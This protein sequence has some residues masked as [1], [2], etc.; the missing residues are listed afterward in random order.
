MTALRFA[1][2]AL[3]GATSLAGC[4]PRTDTPSASTAAS[5]VSR[6]DGVDS[7]RVGDARVMAIL[8]GRAPFP[9]TLFQ[10]LEQSEVER[11]LRTGGEGSQDAQGKFA[12]GGSVWAF[13][14]DVG[15]KRVLVDTGGGSAMAAMGAGRLAGRL[16]AAGVTPASIDA[17]VISHMHGDHVGGLLD[18]EGRPY[19]P[20]ATLHIHADEAGFWGDPARGAA[21][22][23]DQRAGYDAARRM[24]DEYRGK[25]SLFRGRATIVPGFTAEPLIGHTPG[26]TVYRL[27]SA[28]R[29]MAFIGDM[30]HSLAVQMPK[31][32][33]TLVF[34]ND[35]AAARTGRLAFLRANAGRRT[36]FA[37]PH[38]RPGVVTIVSEGEGY[39]AAAVAPAG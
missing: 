38:F 8:D 31:P 33:T 30:I 2:A 32:A 15:G 26:H 14:V 39:R 25:L 35:A 3:I 12:W 7:Y 4:M 18:A 24:L 9:A 10:G 5:P 11:L 6:V 29:D 34:D 23:A 13:L 27:R 28:G 19:F 16:Q 21:A 36:I 20:N 22:P 37:G 17:V 1:A